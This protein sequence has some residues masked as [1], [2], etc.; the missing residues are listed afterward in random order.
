M[1]ALIQKHKE[2][3]DQLREE[4]E[5]LREEIKEGRIQWSDMMNEIELRT[6]A[7]DNHYSEDFYN[8]LGGIRCNSYDFDSVNRKITV[9]GETKRFDTRNFS[10]IADLID[11][12][13]R[14]PILDNGEMRSFSK[15][16][17]FDDG[18]TAT[19]KL[20]L[21]IIKESVSDPNINLN[22]N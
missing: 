3:W 8:E 12:L 6:I 22:L 2:N 14:S 5:G 20:T 4:L 19:L 15:S 9:V 10:M 13:N 1:D 18:Y 7:V 11:E 21:D 17:S 16:G